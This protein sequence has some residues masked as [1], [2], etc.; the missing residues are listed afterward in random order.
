MSLTDVVP[1]PSPS[2]R[3]RWTVEEYHR[4]A[5][6][7]VL[8]ESDRVELVDGEVV[9]KMV[10][11]SRHAAG[12]RRIEQLLRPRAERTGGLLS[13]QSPITLPSVRQ[14]A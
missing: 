2:R 4:L 1:S 12:V 14:R 7:G 13:V 8:S 3:R 5:E 6:A 10:I 11:G 9:E